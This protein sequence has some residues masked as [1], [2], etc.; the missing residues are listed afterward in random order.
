MT[1]PHAGPMA[2]RTVLITGATSGIGRETARGL[3][4]MGAQVAIVGRDRSRTE[5]TAR[6]V[7]AAAGPP[8]ELFVADLSAQSE[9]RRLAD[10]ALDRLPRIHVLVN[11]VGGFWQSRHVTADGL[12]HTFALNHL[13]PYLLTSL[14]LERLRE[15]GPSRV[16]TVSSNA[17]AMGRI[18]FADLQGEWDYSGSRAYDQSKLAN[19]LFAYELA[20]RLG[21]GSAVTS[22]ALHPGLVS[23][24]FG[25]EDPALVQRL[26]VPF[27]RPLMK[28]PT[29][30]A[31]TSIHVASASALD[32]T[33]GRYFAKSKVRRSSKQSYDTTVAARL[34]QVSAE[35]VARPAPPA[36]R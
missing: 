7:R 29:R 33:T 4:A 14:L 1:Q 18:D 13:A 3:A 8:V 36:P 19:L 27:L 15:S 16:V 21:P 26:L 31:A 35:L 17:Q 23:T 32:G 6:D 10:E 20:R 12:E 25:A 30:G 34:W 28:S 2:G 5:A 11:N 24:S 22:N 9:V